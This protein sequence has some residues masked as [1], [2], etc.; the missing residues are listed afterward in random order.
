MKYPIFPITT[1]VAAALAFPLSTLAE[2]T[3][4]ADQLAAK[5]AEFAAS[6][7]DNVKEAFAAGIEAVAESGIIDKAIN[8]G[9][10]APPFTL[11]NAT[12]KEVSLASLLEQGPVVLTWYRG[13]W[14]PYCNIQLI[15]LQD[16][17]PQIKAEGAQLVA[18]TPELPD[19]SLTTKEKDNLEYEILSDVGMKVADEYHIIFK[20]TPEVTEMYKGFFDL[21][22]YN[23]PDAAYDELPLAA[24]YIIQPDGTVSW[25][26]L[27]ADYRQ[28][29]EPADIV[30]A[31]KAVE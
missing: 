18:L 2:D 1:L 4:L 21:K 30:A 12:G 9:D 25:A 3:T 5:Q 16:A 19:K 14:C 7:P 8:V 23:G 24:T 13:G 17:L 26:Y 15:A 6:T 11:K 20:L 28:R 22:E 29:A 31:L 27:N 10:K